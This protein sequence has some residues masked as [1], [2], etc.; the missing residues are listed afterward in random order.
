MLVSLCLDITGQI[1]AQAELE[2]LLCSVQL[3]DIPG[4]NGSRLYS[5]LC[6]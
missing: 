1:E 3:G 6:K 2:S 4:Q 5:D